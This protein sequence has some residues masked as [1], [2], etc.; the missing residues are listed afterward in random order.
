M[1]V[2]ARQYQSRIRLKHDALSALYSKYKPRC[3]A[4]PVSSRLY[5]FSS[6]LRYGRPA[7]TVW[8]SLPTETFT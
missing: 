8:N 7:L 2:M 5:W 6:W 3:T 4:L 1:H